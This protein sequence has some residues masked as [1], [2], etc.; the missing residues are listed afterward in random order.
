MYTLPPST[1]VSWKNDSL[2]EHL[3]HPNRWK[4][5]MVRRGLYGE[6]SKILKPSYS[7]GSKALSCKSST[8]LKVVF[9]VYSRSPASTCHAPPHCNMHSLLPHCF[10]DNGQGLVPVNCRKM[11]AQFFFLLVEIWTS[12][13]QGMLGVSIT[14]SHDDRSMFCHQW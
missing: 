3:R 13:W 10:P 2:S 4:S 7:V 9:G 5:D 12:L 11:W 8:P 6:C 14:Y 1:H